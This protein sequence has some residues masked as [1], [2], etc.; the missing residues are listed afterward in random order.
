MFRAMPATSRMISDAMWV[1]EGELKMPIDTDQVDVQFPEANGP[2]P[3]VEEVEVEIYQKL[4]V[5]QDLASEFRFDGIPMRD[6][7]GNVFVVKVAEVGGYI[8]HLANLAAA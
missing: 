2:G 5:A 8:D 4:T 6:A 3:G 1:Q 7:D